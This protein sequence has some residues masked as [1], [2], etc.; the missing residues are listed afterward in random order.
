MASVGL[1]AATADLVD[2]VLT[3]PSYVFRDEVLT[4]AV[5]AGEERINFADLDTQATKLARIRLA[6]VERPIV[7]HPRLL[8]VA[9]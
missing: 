6:I 7:N 8:V 5:V 9:Q 3:S 4:D 2:V 1:P